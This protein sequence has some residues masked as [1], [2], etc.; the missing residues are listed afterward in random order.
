M[1]FPR[2]LLADHERIVFELRPHWVAVIPALL[3]AAL[4]VVA[5]VALGALTTS[6]PAQ[7]G[8]HV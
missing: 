6:G 3:W 1:G 2:A 5:C 7:I 4:I 8:R